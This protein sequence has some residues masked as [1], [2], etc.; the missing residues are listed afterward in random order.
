MFS[1]LEDG[2]GSSH[3]K[4]LLS[5]EKVSSL[6]VLPDGC[7]EQTM[8]RLAPT[9]VAVRYLDMSDQWFNMPPGAKDN[10]LNFCE[11]GRMKLRPHPHRDEF[12]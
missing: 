11:I 9:A 5:P 7:L 3:A 2:F 10:A 6:I 8:V 4:N 12:R 1:P